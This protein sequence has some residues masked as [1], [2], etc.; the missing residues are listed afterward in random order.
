MDYF[1][2]P[3][4]FQSLRYLLLRIDYQY[5]EPGVEKLD[6]YKRRFAPLLKEVEQ[7]VR[8]CIYAELG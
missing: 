7:A 8:E 5:A 4:D 3:R 2:A 1:L 6:A